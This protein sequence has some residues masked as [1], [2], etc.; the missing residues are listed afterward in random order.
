M[1]NKK[2]K[3][4]AEMLAKQLKKAEKEVRDKYKSSQ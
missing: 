2:G 4:D 3:L 1:Y